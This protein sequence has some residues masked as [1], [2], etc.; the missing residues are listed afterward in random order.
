M[1][2][3][4]DDGGVF[5]QQGSRMTPTNSQWVNNKRITRKEKSKIENENCV[6][7]HS[8]K[9]SKTHSKSPGESQEAPENDTSDQS[10]KTQ[11]SKLDNAL[12][13]GLCQFFDTCAVEYTEF[14]KQWVL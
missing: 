8:I 2:P 11:G 1:G 3:I 7:W 12:P 6:K 13:A 10:I 14:Y 9:I 4:K 5:V